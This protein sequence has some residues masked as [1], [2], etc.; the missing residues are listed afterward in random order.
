MPEERKLVSILFA[1]VTGSTA[2]GDSMDPED[3]RALMS[4]YY[5]HARRIVPSYGG[6]LEKF[7]GDAVMAIFGLHQSHGDDAERALAAA[8]ALR[9]AIATD[10]VL[11]SI[12]RLRIGVNTGEVVATGDPSSGDFLVTGDAVNVSARL[13]QGANPGEIIVSER[14]VHAAQNAF[15]FEEERLLQAKGKPQPLRVF[16][17]QGPRAK[18]QVERPPFVGRRQ[19]LL[20]LEVL[21]ERTL[22]EQRPQLVSI[23]APAGTG[24]SR[25]LEEF[26][27]K[28]DPADGFQVAFSRC[29]PY[30]QT[31]TFWPLRGLLT[32]LLAGEPEKQRVQEIFRQ[33]GYQD[34]DATRLANLVLTTLGMEGESANDRESIFAAWRLFIEALSAQAPR[35]IVFED[36]HWASESLLDLVEHIIHLRTSASL[37]LIALSRPELLDRRPTW[38]GGRQNFTF[39]SLQPLGDRQTRDLVTRLGADIP[40]DIQEQIVTRSGGNPFFALE[41]LHAFTELNLKEQTVKVTSLP[42]TVHAA[43]LA[44]IDLLSRQERSILQAASVASRAFR[45]SLLEAVMAHLTPS[46]IATA[47]DGLL[48]RDM[49]VQMEH[50]RY[51]FRH[52]LVRDVAYGTLSRGERIRLHSKVAL[53]LEASAGEHLDEFIEIIAYH[54]REAI[55]LSRQSA[56]P[57]ALPFKTEDAAHIFARA[58]ILAGRTGSYSEAQHQMQLAIELTPEAERMQLYEEWGDSVLWGDIP[59]EVYRKALACWR[60]TDEKDPLTGARLIRKVLIAS[61]WG[62]VFPT[63]KQAEAEELRTEALHLVA[64]TGDEDEHWYIRLTAC[65]DPQFWSGEKRTSLTEAMV[66]H[67]ALALDA[68]AYFKQQENWEA[69]SQ[70]LD[71]A[72][73]HAIY[74]GDMQAALEGSQQQLTIPNLSPRGWANAVGTIVQYDYINGDFESCLA[75]GK[76]IFANLKPG[77]P[78]AGLGEIA[79]ALMYAAFTCGQW[80]EVEKMRP[81]LDAIRDLVQYDQSATAHLLNGYLSLLWVALARENRPL[82]DAM[83]TIVR[84]HGNLLGAN[85]P[86][87]VEAL[88]TADPQKCTLDPNHPI[89]DVLAYSLFQFLS[90]HGQTSPTGLLHFFLDMGLKYGIFTYIVDIAAALEANDT[91]RLA[92][93]IDEAEAHQHIVHAARMRIVLA[94]RTQDKTQLARARPVLERLGDRLHLRKLEEVEQELQTSS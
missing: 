61:T 74:L 65:F 93:A 52:I 49:I 92:Q 5:D 47:L 29:L 7:I 86:T 8:L 84:K 67:R 73:R 50:E 4:R 41:L 80:D 87:Y 44:R 48:A 78:I 94:Q 71:A 79:G 23:V 53:W 91:I 32:E 83:S 45:T 62:I 38:G 54:Y 34:E 77:Q 89:E 18:R 40:A 63:I 42:D 37:L 25:L 81:T 20:Q 66:Q 15:L 1:D 10:D 82:I 59:N 70:A 3:V 43:V 27:Q 21:K 56:I 28:F 13:Q 64:N 30:G 46:E 24:K 88:L 36:L 22:E 17:L 58:G 90:E 51:N 75:R 26:L 69:M 16:P 6:T 19:D 14:T 12:F 57:L 39:L 2:L 60:T 9:D 55:Q 85:F 76:D 68:I 11:G 31:L 33:G 35:I 72:I